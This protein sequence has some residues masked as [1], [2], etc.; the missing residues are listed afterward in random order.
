MAS[1]AAQPQ[2]MKNQGTGMNANG[3]EERI[4][5]NSIDLGG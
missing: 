3:R 1:L 4:I 2:P 5:A